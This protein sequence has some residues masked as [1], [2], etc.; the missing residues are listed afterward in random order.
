[1]TSITEKEFKRFIGRG[2]SAQRA[3]DLI[4]EKSWQQQV[5]DLAR[6]LGWKTYHTY[7][8]RRSDPGFPDLILARK[9]RLVVAELKMEKRRLTASQLFWIDAF[10]EIPCAEVY[11][12]RPSDLDQV[13]K[14]LR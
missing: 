5:K 11:I 7:D 10:K 8:S 4:S 6:L 3:V 14:I 1:M 13:Q 2:Q 9:K 12:W